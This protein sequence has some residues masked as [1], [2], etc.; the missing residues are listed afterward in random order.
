MSHLLIRS[1]TEADLAAITHIY[2]HHVLH[3]TGTFETTP[4][5][6]AEMQNRRADVLSK[7][8]PW[9]VICR[10]Q[11]VL[12]FAYAN[13]FKPRPAYRFSVED[14]IYLAPQAAGQ[15]LGKWLMTELLAQLERAGIRR[16][17][18]VIGDSDNAGSV[19]LHTAMGFERA[20]MIPSCGWKLGRW[21]DIVLMQR[22]LGAG[23]ATAPESDAKTGAI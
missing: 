9:L 1:S 21:L 13:W 12:G 14:S 23:D 16:V 4:P 20:G 18:A 22:S 6:A 11:E 15:G 10:D 5:T 19:G 7:G 8:L 17:M 2:G 3:G